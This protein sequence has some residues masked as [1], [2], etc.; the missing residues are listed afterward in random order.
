M[1]Y[2]QGFYKDNKER[3]E[4]EERKG[5]KEASKERETVKRDSCILFSPQIFGRLACYIDDM[6]FEVQ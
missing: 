1:L 6:N 5:K 4:Y 2:V 3:I